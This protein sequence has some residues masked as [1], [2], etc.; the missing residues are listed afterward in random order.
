MGELSTGLR[1]ATAEVHERAH[2][3]TYM[4]ALL[5]GRL[6]LSAYTLLAEQY[7]A[8]YGALEAAGDAL[9]GD[10]AAGPFVID[11]LRRLPALRRDVEALGGSVEAPRVLPA[12]ATYVAR[13]GAAAGDGP[14]FVAHHYTRYLGDLAGGQVV[15]KVLERT[16]GVTGP[17]ALFYD[18]SA[19]GSPSRFR[20]R[21]RALLDAAPWDDIE[22]RRVADE[23]VRAFEL[24]IAVFEELAAAAGLP[25]AA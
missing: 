5:A 19:L 8:I 11:E 6:P 3:S 22:Q 12:T 24:N 7:L 21:Y 10:P 9:A 16:Y 17:G 4:A 13:L 25:A 18:F 23:A 15:G 14:V 1:Q 2:H 20:A